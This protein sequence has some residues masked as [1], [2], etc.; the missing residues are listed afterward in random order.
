[1]KK[2]KVDLGQNKYEVQIGSGL[3]GQIADK[4]RHLGFKDK[5]AII[6]NPTVKE[7]YGDAIKASLEAG[8]FRAA[9]F[10]VPDGE[11]YKSLKWAGNLYRKLNRFQAERMTPILAVGGGV[12]GDLA[13]FVAAT[14]MRGVPLLHIPTSLLA[15]VD[16]SIGGKVAINYNRL[17][18]TIGAFYQPKLVLSDITTLKTLPVKELRN[19]LAEIIKYAIIADKELFTIL[20]KDMP[21]I[22]SLDLELLEEVIYRCAGIKARIVEKDEKDLSMRNVLNYG[23]TFGHAIETVSNFQVQ[24]G[25]AVAVGMLAAAM[26]SQRMSVLPAPDLDAIKTLIVRAG[27]PI[28]IPGV[29]IHKIMDMMEHDKKKTDGKIRFVLPRSVGE[30]FIT[31]GVNNSLLEQV[32]EEMHE[33][34]Q[35]LRHAG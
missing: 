9:L 14:Y 5:A 11:E 23:H 8:R 21:R 31:D 18:N 25:G 33:E 3:V 13:G 6:T 4:L 29:D 32:L 22:K 35:N 15:Q 34:T 26:V 30:M 27:L 2:I 1:M 17:K 7:L 19:G 12:I 16:S 28:K 20:T 10:E 24:H